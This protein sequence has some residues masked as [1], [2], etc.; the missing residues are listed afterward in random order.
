MLVYPPCD[1]NAFENETNVAEMLFP[2]VRVVSIGQFRPEKN[3]RFVSVRY[4][5]VE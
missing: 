5:K 4:F 2:D 3:H 1:V